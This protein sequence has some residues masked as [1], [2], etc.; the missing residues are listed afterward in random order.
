MESLPDL[1]NLSPYKKRLELIRLTAEQVIKD[2]G[3]HGFEVE[4]SGNEETAYVELFNQIR[5]LI[6]HLMEKNMGRLSN[7]LY[8]IDLSETK[9]RKILAGET[10]TPS[11]ELTELI[12][13][14]ELQKV[15]IRTYYSM[16]DKE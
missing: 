1:K 5:P 8:S 3:L 7:L 10:A 2:F 12:L 14:R 16:K 13:E 15:V 4:F 6:E 9:V 11:E